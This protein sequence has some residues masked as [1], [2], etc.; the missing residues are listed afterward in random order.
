MLQLLRKSSESSSWTVALLAGLRT[1]ILRTNCLAVSET[2]DLGKQY[3]PF[4][5]LS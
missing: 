1:S 5:I 4:L 2:F 3:S